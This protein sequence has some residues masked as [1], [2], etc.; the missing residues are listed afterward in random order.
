MLLEILDSGPGFPEHDGWRRVRQKRSVGPHQA[1]S[2]AASSLAW[3]GHKLDFQLLGERPALRSSLH[4]T[5]GRDP[6]SSQ[7][8]NRR[9]ELKMSTNHRPLSL[10]QPC[11]ELDISAV[12]PALERPSS[13]ACLLT[14]PQPGE[15]SGGLGGQ[16][17][18]I[19]ACLSLLSPALEFPLSG[20]WPAGLAKAS[21]LIP[22]ES[23]DQ[24]K[25]QASG[26]K[27]QPQW[28]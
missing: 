15:M 24:S 4:C 14:P 22:G 18:H 9:P 13:L 20:E 7:H 10:K 25:E 17:G 1:E 27:R 23:R 28:T 6:P 3:A 26:T 5:H 2:T 11:H 16:A 21:L 8:S 19:K 12:G